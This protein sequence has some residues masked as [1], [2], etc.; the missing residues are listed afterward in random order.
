MS[1]FIVVLCEMNRPLS[2]RW[3]SFTVL[4]R[5]LPEILSALALVWLLRFAPYVIKQS[6]GKWRAGLAR[7]GELRYR[8]P[9]SCAGE[10]KGT[11]RAIQWVNE[12]VPRDQKLLY[13]GEMSGGIRLRYYTLPRDARWYYLYSS[14]DVARLPEV[15]TETRPEWVLSEQS[16]TL[17]KQGVPPSWTP[18][19]Q[20]PS[21]R[22]QA[23]KVNHDL[24]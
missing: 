14:A 7:L 2:D 1:P 15:I 17:R 12:T 13:I 19:W 24:E 3:R 20:D 23:F 8:V 5:F 18:V 10:L 21:S 9:P 22:L 6:H 11:A 4:I 16:S